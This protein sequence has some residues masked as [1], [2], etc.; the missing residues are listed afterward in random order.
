V[1]YTVI[2]AL[3]SI[4]LGL[5]VF[6]YSY[7]FYDS[8]V[9]TRPIVTALTPI[10]PGTI[11]QKTQ[12]KAREL[13]RGLEREPIYT[14]PDEVVGK[15][16][17]TYIPQGGLIYRESVGGP[18]ALHFGLPQKAIISIPIEPQRALG[19]TLLP[20]Q[21]ISISKICYKGQE[22]TE[23][24]VASKVVVVGAEKQASFIIVALDPSELDRVLQALGE[25][26][27]GKCRIWLV[28]PPY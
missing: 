6:A 2:A 18:E 26:L 1:K 19:G 15:V 12:L 16:A 17:K 11:I 13:P 27:G 21:T 20:G 23:E 9:S 22:V 24:M 25:E 5:L 14:S 8:I 4:L 28:L 7:A 10:Q 3:V